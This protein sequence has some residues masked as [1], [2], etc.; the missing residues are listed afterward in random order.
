MNQII[1]RRNKL[2]AHYDKHSAVEKAEKAGQIAD[3]MEVRKEIME[4]ILAGVITLEAGQAE[5][6]NI[7]RSAKKNGKLTRAQVWKQS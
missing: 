5:L 1:A 4:R 6:A 3:S 7:K 2:E